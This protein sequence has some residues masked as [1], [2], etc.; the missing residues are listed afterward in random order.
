MKRI[1]ILLLALMPFAVNA[2]EYIQSDTQTA[3]GRTIQ[4]KPIPFFSRGKLYVAGHNYMKSNGTELYY[5]TIV[6]TEE[7]S[8]WNVG[9]GD[10]A[11]FHML[12]GKDI[13]C[14]TIIESSCEQNK[15]STYM[16]TVVYITPM[17][18]VHDMLDV[19]QSISINKTENGEKVTTSISVDF[20]TASA[21]MMSY[22][23]LLSKTGR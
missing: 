9:I 22:L 2:Q 11:T 18:Q 21:L 14:K 16:I 1:L 5:T 7:T 20:D 13:Q 4:M 19:I 6:C 23:E 10:T 12:Q 8:K 3:N 15:D 17:D